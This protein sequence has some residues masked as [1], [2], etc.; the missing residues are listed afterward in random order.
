M[1]SYILKSLPPMMEAKIEFLAPGFSWNQ[2]GCC[3]HLGNEP[4]SQRVSS[5]LP[6]SN[7]YQKDLKCYFQKSQWLSQ[8]WAQR[9][10]D[11]AMFSFSS[12]RVVMR[13]LV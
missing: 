1:I 3:D 6:I 7:K 12:G 5:P 9:I 2:T 10:E 4:M 13:L 11:E 8:T